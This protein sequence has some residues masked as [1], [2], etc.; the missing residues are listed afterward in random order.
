VPAAPIPESRNQ[1]STW[2]TPKYQTCLLYV[3]YS[4]YNWAPKYDP[5]SHLVLCCRACPYGQTGTWVMQRS[6]ALCT[7]GFKKCATS[8]R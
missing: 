5:Q 6:C 3:L 1:V 4:V 2:D 7:W 8:R